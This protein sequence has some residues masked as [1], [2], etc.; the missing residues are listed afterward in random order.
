LPTPKILTE[1]LP[2]VVETTASSPD[3]CAMLALAA[4]RKPFVN[5]NRPA[6]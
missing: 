6:P 3:S 2:I 1:V 5:L 4:Q